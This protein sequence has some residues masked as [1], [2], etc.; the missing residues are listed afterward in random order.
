MATS[1][2]KFT[3]VVALVVSAASETLFPGEY[4][5]FASMTIHGTNSF[6]FLASR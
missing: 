5:G 4:V 2:F 1:E 3:G 6:A